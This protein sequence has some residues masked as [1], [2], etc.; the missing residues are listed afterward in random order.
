MGLILVST[1]ANS[2][3]V[4]S[5]PQLL[6]PMIY[7]HTVRYTRNSQSHIGRSTTLTLFLRLRFMIMNDMI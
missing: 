5:Q 4:F 1:I 2:S 3:L 7:T 6:S